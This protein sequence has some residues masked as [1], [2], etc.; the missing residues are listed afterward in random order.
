[1]WLY[2]IE[3]QT[4]KP[5]ATG[6]PVFIDA[7]FSP[8]GRWLAYVSSDGG[9][10]REVFVQALAGEERMTPGARVQVS[11]AGGVYPHWR[12]DGRELIYVD[13]DQRVTAVG[14]EEQDG[15][16]RVGTPQVLFTIDRPIV[17]IDATPDHR[18]LLVATQVQAE[19]DPLRVV[20]D[21]PAE[22]GAGVEGGE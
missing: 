16:L 19:S 7:R 9:G 17:S 15:R 5:F 8:D 4:A 2:S 10:R 21:W 18:R 11:T 13:P 3:Q 12:E 14:I 6:D 1:V 22:A 20:L